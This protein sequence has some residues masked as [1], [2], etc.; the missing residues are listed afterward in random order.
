MKLERDTRI[1][2]LCSVLEVDEKSFWKLIKGKRSATQFGSFMIDGKLSNSPVEIINMWFEHFKCLGIPSTHNHYDSSF[3]DFVANAVV[4]K[5]KSVLTDK[6]NSF[7]I[8]SPIEE[9]EVVSVCK[10]LTGG[11]AGGICQTT[12]EHI[13]FGGPPLWNLLYKLYNQMF[14]SSAVPTE[15]LTGIVLPLFK[16]K[17]LKASEKDNY[18]GITLFPVVIKVFEMVILKRLEKF[19]NDY[20][21]HLQFGFKNGTGCI[22]A[23]FLINQA[24][25]YFVERGSKVFAC[26]LDIRKAFDT[27]WIDGLFFK[28]FTELGIQGKMFSIVKALYSKTQCFVYFNGSTSDKFE[29]LQGTGQGRILSAFMY[30]IYIN[31]LIKTIS[32]CEYSLSIGPL[33][34][35]SPTFADDMTLLSLFPSFLQ[36]LMK[37]AFGYSQ[38]WRFDYN[39]TKSGVVTFGEHGPTHFREKSCRSWQLGDK[40]VEEANQYKNL[41]IVKNY[42]GSFQSDVDEAIEKTRKKAGMILS[43]CT[44]RKNTNPLIYI[45]LWKQ[46]CLPTLLFGSELWILSQTKVLQLERCQRWFL[47]SFTVGTLSKVV[48]A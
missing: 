41:G 36:F 47:R 6:S 11:T 9:S 40:V 19:A 16:G 1:T 2:D 23:S 39:E 20:F 38:K 30:K 46:A 42:V 21:S 18:R 14:E 3:C 34:L 22:E 17:G 37:K 45:K 4:T 43:G 7:D 12:Y 27:V 15:S 13:K 48:F 32:D 29:V 33:K 35:G 31:E 25:S 5:F 24:I 10:S 26:F 8:N 44:D 28:L